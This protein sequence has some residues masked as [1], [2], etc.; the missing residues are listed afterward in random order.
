[1]IEEIEE[2]QT[3]VIDEFLKAN[4]D[5]LGRFMPSLGAAVVRTKLNHM[6]A[7]NVVS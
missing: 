3:S 4:H 1:M 2:Y 7:T 6:I 5:Q